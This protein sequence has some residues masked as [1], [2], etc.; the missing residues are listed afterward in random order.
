MFSYPCGFVLVSGCHGYW[1][2]LLW[3]KRTPPGQGSASP[4]QPPP[5]SVSTTNLPWAGSKGKNLGRDRYPREV[6]EG[7]QLSNSH[8][9]TMHRASTSPLLQGLV[10]EAEGGHLHPQ[11]CFHFTD[12]RMGAQGWRQL[13]HQEAELGRGDMGHSPEGLPPSPNLAATGGCRMKNGWL[14]GC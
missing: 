10:P 8:S 9:P 2:Q 7:S 1:S 5:P 14:P 3:Q 6:G 4:H 11:L 12:G 13:W